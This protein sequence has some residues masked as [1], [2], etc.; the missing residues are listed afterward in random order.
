[1]A[2]AHGSLQPRLPAV[3]SLTE[4]F[5]PSQRVYVAGLASESAVL[6][7]ELHRFPGRAASVEF[8][9]VQLPGVDQTDYLAV[10]PESRTVAFF[11][12]PAVRQAL[13]SQRASL[14]P[15][16]YN[17]IARHLL[18]APP[19]DVAV[20]QFTLPDE[21]GWCSPGLSCDFTPLV[22]S[23]AQRRVGHL[24]PVLPR[25]DSSFRVHMSEFDTIVEAPAAP[26]GV[27][28]APGNAVTQQIALNAAQLVRDGDTLQFG[29]GGVMPPIARALH[30]H[31]HLRIHSGMVSSW[32]QTLWDS[33][34]LDPDAR[35]VAGVVLGDARLHQFVGEVGRMYLDDVR[36]THAVDVIA[37]LPRF[38]AINGAVEVDLFGQINSERADGTL[39][40]GAG[41]LPAFAHGSQLAPDGRLL[42]C[43]PAS[44]RGGQVSRIVPALGSGALCTVPRHLADAVV[45]EYGVAELRGLSM[46]ARAQTLISIAHP[47]HRAVLADAW[48]EI[49]R[50]L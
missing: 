13:F 20:A 18:D 22:W 48:D 36:N 24:N 25:V 35:I 8:T 10:H 6:R 31:R 5:R 49:A 38:V 40:A 28:E 29:I 32:V 43:L 1:M 16:D 19:F 17:G 30:S 27:A 41:G 37:T 33:G 50:K 23:R 9:S 47:D 26:L 39:Q 42:I 7:E 11:M 15:L 45:T 21:Q 14:Y 4:H 44:A 3:E 34:A 46:T 2:R 12:T